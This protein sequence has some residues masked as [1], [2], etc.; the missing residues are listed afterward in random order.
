V[1]Q[2]APP[3]PGGSAPAGDDAASDGDGLTKRR[4]AEPEENGFLTIDT[5]PWAQV[6]VGGRSLGNTPVI[7]ARL[8]VGRH[9]LRLRNPEAGITTTY[10]VDIRANETTTRRLGL[11]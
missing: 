5:M 3:S 11:E 6:S 2:P 9:T 7:K 10:T 8:P 1:E 4:A